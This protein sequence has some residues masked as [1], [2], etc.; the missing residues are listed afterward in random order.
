MLKKRAVFVNIFPF[1]IKHYQY[2]LFLLQ[3]TLFSFTYD[4]FT[5]IYK[6]TCYSTPNL[7]DINVTFT[8]L[9]S[10]FKTSSRNYILLF[11]TLTD[12]SFSII[13]YLNLVAW[14]VN[15]V[16]TTTNVLQILRLLLNFSIEQLFSFIVLGNKDCDM[17]SFKFLFRLYVTLIMFPKRIYSIV[18]KGTTFVKM[19]F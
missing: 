1:S 17:S 14:Q 8:G 16:G 4:K 9:K 13:L 3:L 15:S 5:T 18:T 19:F 2:L 7:N 10:L 11:T 6:V 12:D